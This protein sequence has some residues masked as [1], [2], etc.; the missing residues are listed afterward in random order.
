M[1]LRPVTPRRTDD[2]LHTMGICGHLDVEPNKSNPE[3]AIKA[4]RYLG[5]KHVRTNGVGAP[6]RQIVDTLF[7]QDGAK[8]HGTASGKP[9]PAPA[10]QAEVIAAIR[11]RVDWIIDNGYR[12]RY[13]SVES[14]NEWNSV[15]S[16][17]KQYW[18]Q[19]LQWAQDEL[20]DYVRTKLR[21]GV[22]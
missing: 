3:W 7:T 8:F 9:G 10:T 16:G 6:T 19:E 17:R 15:R 13:D 20:Y 1:A 11:K 4:I 2:I 5:V 18:A 22:A 14:F 21:G 12:P